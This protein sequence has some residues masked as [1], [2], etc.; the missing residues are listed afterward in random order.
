MEQ[1]D[2]IKLLK[3]HGKALE[4]LKNQVK[5]TIQLKRTIETLKGKIETLE[6][7][8][9]GVT[10][11]K[12][13]LEAQGKANE[14][15]LTQVESLSSALEGLG[16]DVESIQGGNIDPGK[17]KDLMNRLEYCEKVCQQIAH[18]ASRVPAPPETGQ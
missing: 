6:K 9:T 5:E 18:L 12:A 4:S 16:A 13:I 17:L 3:Q 10:D 8:G 7:A 15:F 14:G 11:L 2:I 1:K